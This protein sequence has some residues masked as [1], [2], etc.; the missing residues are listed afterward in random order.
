[1][2]E[3]RR[4]KEEALMNKTKAS[5]EE[6]ERLERQLVSIYLTNYLC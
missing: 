2:A 5:K 1:M 4:Q 3:L 6:R